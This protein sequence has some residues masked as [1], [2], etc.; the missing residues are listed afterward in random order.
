MSTSYLPGGTRYTNALESSDYKKPYGTSYKQA[1]WQRSGHRPLAVPHRINRLLNEHE[2]SPHGDEPTE[3]PTELDPH[4][5][6]V[7]PEHL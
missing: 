1:H 4:S 2:L 3:H 6:I 7:Q 5:Q